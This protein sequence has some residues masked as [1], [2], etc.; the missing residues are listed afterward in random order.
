[1]DQD[2]PNPQ[3]SDSPEASSSVDLDDYSPY[4]GKL[5][6]RKRRW[7]GVLNVEGEFYDL[8]QEEADRTGARVT[9][10]V[11]RHAM[12]SLHAVRDEF[13]SK[14][15]GSPVVKLLGQLDERHRKRDEDTQA[16]LLALLREVTA[17]QAANH[18]LAEFVMV[19]IPGPGSNLPDNPT[20]E[21]KAVAKL[22][23][24]RALAG[25]RPR[26]A[27]FIKRSA[28]N[29][30]GGRAQL[31]QDIQRAAQDMERSAQSTDEGRDD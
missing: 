9:S 24:E 28:Q 30:R 4:K 23:R 3:A 12:A 14:V 6:S 13:A 11:R 5:R 20:D 19:N 10:I 25:V 26:Y 22:E 7:S 1:M 27:H 8:V 2:N 29:L 18:A 31:S 16:I 21:Q 15:P 17:L